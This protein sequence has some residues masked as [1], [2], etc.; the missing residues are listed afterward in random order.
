[1]SDVNDAADDEV[2][3]YPVPRARM[4]QFDANSR[5]AGAGGVS[6]G[7][8]SQGAAP[9][10]AAANPALASL[11]FQGP[12]QAIY[13]QMQQRA[14]AQ[15][16]AQQAY[17]DSLQKQEGALSQMG[18][19][20]LDRA[21]LLFQAAGALGKTTRSGGFGETLGNVGEAMAGPL[22]K[23]AEAQRQRQQQLAQLQAARAKLGMEMSGQGV[24]PSDMLSLLKAQQDA[25]PKLSDTQRLL[26]DPSLTP[27]E[28]KAGL[29]KA[30][31]LDEAEKELKE[32][33][34]TVKRPDGSEFSVVRRGGRSYDPITNEPIDETK[35]AATAATAQTTERQDH[36]LELG[37]PLLERDPYANL[38]PKDREK[39]RTARY[40]TDSRI[41]QKQTDE[42]PDSVL[43][44]EIAKLRR[45]VVL[46]NE[47]R[48][49]G[50]FWG[51]TLNIAP[52]AQQMAGIESEL[53]IGAGK[54][55]KGAASDRDVKMFGSAVPS[56]SKD[57]EA[58]R[59][60]SMFNQL[61]NRT[62]LERREFMRDYLAVN[63]TLEGADRKW[64][65]YVNDNPFFIYPEK[66][67]PD[68]LDITKLQINKARPSYQDYFRKEL[69]GGATPVVRD[70][71]GRLIIKE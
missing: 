56:T 8:L 9:Q 3:S 64:N 51:K 36:A 20:D 17:L 22:S 70:A 15:R 19:S 13:Q 16:Q 71:Q 63:K 30:L 52:S 34:K 27:E 43:R 25:Q 44:D 6:G 60:I 21:S 42:V 47:N 59:N 11:Q 58:N 2:P 55:L 41:L 7:P 37:V 45:F 49:T 29:R 4:Q 5:A 61:K 24:S 33:V 31:K 65:K 14:D 38:Q 53:T 10:A 66:F 62:E 18:M 39:A 54:D 26:Q 12:Y 23:Q 57:F 1:M 46:N 50:P 67:N 48:S 68:K 69:S 35:I 40:N 28:R 32:E